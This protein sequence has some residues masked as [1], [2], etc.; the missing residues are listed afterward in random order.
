MNLLLIII[1]INIVEP[2][3]VEAQITNSTLFV[4]RFDINSM[5]TNYLLDFEFIRK[6]AKWNYGREFVYENKGAK[7]CVFITIGLHSSAES[8]N[9]I[10][11]SYLN[12][13]SARM[14]NGIKNQILLGDKFWYLTSY[15]D[16][17][18]FINIVFIRENA[19][20]ILS[21]SPSFSG[22]FSLAKRI[23]ESIINRASFVTLNSQIMVPEIKTL[24]INSDLVKPNGSA[25]ITINASDVEDELLE[26]QFYPGLIKEKMDPKNVFTYKSSPNFIDKTTGIQVL[27]A[28]A[29]NESNV[30]SPMVELKIR[31]F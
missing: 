18:K 3:L 12:E 24:S 30:V 21:C 9:I 11:N 8:A 25:K 13:M 5:A 15:S 22:L 2:Q 26:Y 16:S 27:K 28:V 14:T 7:E 6:R 19:L 29:I 17:S 31:T 4:T 1:F 23:D 20:F 10:A